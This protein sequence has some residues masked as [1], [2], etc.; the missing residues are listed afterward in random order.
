[1]VC[2]GFKQ[3]FFSSFVSACGF[4]VLIERAL[5]KA[6]YFKFLFQTHFPFIQVVQSWLKMKGSVPEA[7]NFSHDSVNS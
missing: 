4:C 2:V 3:F 1:M 5:Q 6:A 7:Q